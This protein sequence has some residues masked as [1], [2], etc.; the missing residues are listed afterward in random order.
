MIMKKRVLAVL[1]LFMVL[2]PVLAQQPRQQGGGQPRQ[3]QQQGQ[4]PRFD[5][6]EFTK[7]MEGYISMKAGLTREESE[8]FFPIYREFKEKQRDLTF[9]Q[10]RLKR[11]KPAN[12]KEYDK[13]ITRIADL[14]IQI[15]KLEQTYFPRIC[16]VIPAKKFHMVLQAENDF[17][18]DMVRQ[19]QWGGM[20]GAPG[21]QQQ[22]RGGNGQQPW[23][24]NGQQPQWGGHQ[25]QQQKK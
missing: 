18:R 8:K 3:G 11:E 10:Q 21:Q 4:L 9:Q 16:K 19:P 14:S 13:V 23:R 2:M 20:Q 1:A 7:R 17:H 12:D 24:G 25:P 15:A 5:P 22:W 6:Q